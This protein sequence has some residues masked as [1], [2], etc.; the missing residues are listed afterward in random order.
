MVLPKNTASGSVPKSRF[1]LRVL[2]LA[3]PRFS[4]LALGFFLMCANRLCNAVFP[5]SMKYLIDEGI[6]KQHR[7]QLLLVLAVLLGVT[8]VQGITA[9]IS[10]EVLPRATLRLVND[11]R[12]RVF[13]HIA[14]LPLSFHDRHKTGA[15]I[16]RIMTDTESVKNLMGSGLLEFLG[17]IATVSI[18]VGILLHTS[19]ILT[20]ILI[21]SLAVHV[22]IIR[23]CTRVLRPLYLK[24]S[25]LNAD[26]TGRLAES[27]GG[28]RVVKAYRAEGREAATFR[29]GAQSLL[30]NAMKGVSTSAWMSMWSRLAFGGGSALVMYMG[31]RQVFSGTLTLGGFAT[32]TAVSS[33]LVTT[34]MQL[35]SISSQI[36]EAQA[37]MERTLEVLDQ[38][39]EHHN[40]R[41]TVSLQELS[42][43]VEFDGVTFAY[44]PG[45]PVLHDISFRAEP[46]SVTALVGPS[47]A[48]KSTLVS[49]IAGFY[50]PLQGTIRVD[51]VDLSTLILSSY[52]AKMGIVLQDTFLFAGSIHD[53]VAFSRPDASRRE[54]LEACRIGRVDEFAEQ[55]PDGYNTVVGERGVRLSGGQKQRISIARAILA[56]PRILILD[57]ATS[58]LDSESEDLIEQGLSNALE[59]CTTFVI[60]HRLSTT[61]RADQILAIENGRIVE[62]GTH[63]SL[64]R[65]RARYYSLYTKQIQWEQDTPTMSEARAHLFSQG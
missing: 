3:R 20:A 45:K 35:S 41:R 15:L 61:R 63:E 22:G 57:E 2:R 10:S 40:Q 5:Y 25:R 29:S 37:G 17:A 48:G 14:W 34:V 59:N 56:K 32:F 19:V 44:E 30:E 28:M 6:V 60:A 43:E 36:S 64:C 7:Q 12:N 47:G 53:N 51:G 54:V 55:F 65:A 24:R 52:R 26:L 42:G 4:V 33:L 49:L 50:T 39:P 27:L 46:G 9:L 31:A 13:A 62:R 11:L 16:S 23:W 1:L 8:I 58:S 38:E 18:C 21:G